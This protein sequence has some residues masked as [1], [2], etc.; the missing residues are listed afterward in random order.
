MKAAL[1]AAFLCVTP[2]AC[3][4]QTPDL[5]KTRAAAEKGD[6]KA[7]YAMG[8][9]YYL[10]S[11]VARNLKAA[12]HL[13]KLSAEQGLA[14]AQM[15]YGIFLLNGFDDVAGDRALGIKWIHKAADQGLPEA[16]A[17]VASGYYRGVGVAAD[18]VEACK[19]ETLATK[20]DPKY[21]PTLKVMRDGLSPDHAAEC[22]ARAKA[23]RPAK[24]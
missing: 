8:S 9:A 21:A 22:D 16:Q 5:Q 15:A 1:I 20:A 2:L 24:N 6:A 4:A 13:Y 18:G 19:W 17:D 3:A 12:R 14:E 11:G 10:G 7:Q 23:W